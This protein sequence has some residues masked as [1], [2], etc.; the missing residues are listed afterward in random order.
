MYTSTSVV[1]MHFSTAVRSKHYPNIYIGNCRHEMI[2]NQVNVQYVPY[3][4]S[5]SDAKKNT[6]C[7]PI[8][9]RLCGLH[10][11]TKRLHHT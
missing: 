10:F 1:E 3:N 11:V 6:Y 9:L 4:N 8:Q 2:I 7:M 5:C